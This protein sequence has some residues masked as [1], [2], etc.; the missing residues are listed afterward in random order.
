[1][2]TGA[3]GTLFAGLS[4]FISDPTAYIWNVIIKGIRANFMALFEA[5]LTEEKT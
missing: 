1:L 5:L 2:V 3:V 4:T